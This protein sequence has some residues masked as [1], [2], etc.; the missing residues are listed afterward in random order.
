MNDWKFKPFVV[1]GKNQERFDMWIGRITKSHKNGRFVPNPEKSFA[2]LGKPLSEC[3]IALL[4]TG[5]VHLADQPP[6]E[7]LERDGD[8][9]YREIPGDTPDA[10]IRFSHSHYDTSEAEKDPNCMF[11]LARLRDLASEGYIGGA[12]PLHIGMMGFVP[13]IENILKETGPEV[14]QKLVD[15]GTDAVLLTP[16]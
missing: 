6:F 10:E 2:P 15:A 14:G 3:K 4:S 5:G 12:A 1:D 16:G 7:L 8:W 11:P 9:S 13:A